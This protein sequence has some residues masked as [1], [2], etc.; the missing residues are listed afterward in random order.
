[1]TSNKAGQIDTSFQ[2][3]CPSCGGREWI[4]TEIEGERL[5]NRESTRTSPRGQPYKTRCLHSHMITGVMPGPAPVGVS[6]VGPASEPGRLERLFMII[7]ESPAGAA[8]PVVTTMR[9]AIAVNEAWD[10]LT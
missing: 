3:H 4:F 8:L 9:I 2:A 7:V 10:T 1:M 6:G 5:C